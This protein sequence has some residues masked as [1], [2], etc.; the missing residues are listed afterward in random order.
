M[1]AKLKPEIGAIALRYGAANI[2]VFGSVARGS[3]HADSD[4][5]L[6]VTLAAG[7]TLLDLVGLEEDLT[8]LLGRKVDVVVDGGLSPYIGPT[9]LA[10]AIAL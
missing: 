4:I 3:D 10:E 5:D 9:I 6:L 1:L 2:R 7:R 8:N